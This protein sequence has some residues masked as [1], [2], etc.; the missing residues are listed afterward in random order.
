MAEPQDD[1][2]PA[3]DNQPVPEIELAPEKSETTPRTDMTVAEMRAW[4]RDWIA[5]ATGQPADAI[6]DA[7]L[8]G[9]QAVRPVAHN[10]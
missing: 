8:R 5:T 1:S 9:V 6:N 10:P 4:L 7:F 2:Q 3:D